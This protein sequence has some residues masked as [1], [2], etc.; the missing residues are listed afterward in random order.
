MDERPKSIWKKS[1]KGSN[2]LWLLLIPFSLVFAVI[3][4]GGDVPASLKNYLGLPAYA[5]LFSLFVTLLVLLAVKFFRWIFSWRNF[6]RFLFGCACAATLIALFYAEENWRGRHD[7]ERYKHEWEARGEKFDFADFVPP[8]V[9]ADQNFA[10]T[11]IIFTSYGQML[12]RDG[13]MISPDK[14]DTNF[15]N[16]LKMDIA[17]NDDWAMTH[18]T[19]NSIG[20]WQTTKTSDLKVWQNYYRALAAP[21]NEFPVA[22]QPQ[23]P[24]ADVMLA[25]SKYDPVI[26]ELREASKLPYSRFPLEY[27]KDDPAAILLPHLA[28]LKQCSLAL[29]LRA[30]AELQNGQ[31]EK[32]FDDIKLSLRL[33]DSI[34]TEPFIITHLVRMAILQI[35]LQ[36]IWEGL[37]EHKWSDAQ[38]AELNLE[39]S[40]L[41]FPAD[42][43]HSVRSERAYHGKIVDWIEQKRSRYWL[44]VDMINN[45]NQP[46]TM[47]NFLETTAFYLAPKGWFYQNEIT[48][49]QMEQQWNLPLVD[50]TNRIVSPK[51]VEHAGTALASS[52]RPTLFNFFARLL[53]PGLGNFAQ[54]TAYAQNAADLAR[55]AIALERYRL[56]HGGF[57]ESLEA[58]AARF[59]EKI[60]HDIIN[61]ESLHYRRT[62]DGQYIL[63][64]VGWNETDD[65]GVV[66]LTSN[67]QSADNRKGDWVWRYPAK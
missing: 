43:A 53:L 34:R 49:A 40:K 23:S 57:P 52:L 44:L 60:P 46:N 42:Y 56:A 33:A 17:R 11:P 30:L 66:G 15:V 61:G 20:D 18:S 16:R 9:P 37:A 2:E 19:T 7:W 54:K 13:R 64:S 50:A 36:P 35:T 10:L 29:Q 48:I 28:V 3:Y 62:G 67:G 8:P 38:L 59:L 12:T 6:K 1:L 24:A 21:T 63:Y 65:D 47:E 51:I 32:S 25:L 41:D 55:V 58:L 26:E 31:T 22:P 45:N 39:L 4:A 5:L 14:R 27:D